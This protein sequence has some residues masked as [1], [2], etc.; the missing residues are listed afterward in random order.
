MAGKVIHA[1]KRN[2]GRG[3]EGG[4]DEIGRLMSVTGEGHSGVVTQIVFG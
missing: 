2:D 1:A 3:R 4:Y